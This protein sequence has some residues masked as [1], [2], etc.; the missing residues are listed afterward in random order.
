MFLPWKRDYS[1]L[2]H[3]HLLEQ[4]WKQLGLLQ[5]SISAPNTGA[6][7]VTGA[8]SSQIR[9]IYKAAS[10]SKQGGASLQQQPLTDPQLC[11]Y[12]VKGRELTPSA[13]LE[14]LF[15]TD[16]LVPSLKMEMVVQKEEM[17]PFEFDFMGL[18]S[19]GNYRPDSFSTNI[20]TICL[21]SLTPMLFL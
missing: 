9:W 3:Y 21:A 2:L 12:L 11:C 1:Y 6:L 7:P 15:L 18:L 19:S 16:P 14:K 4:V 10:V 5:V 17:K 20:K 8:L 13:S